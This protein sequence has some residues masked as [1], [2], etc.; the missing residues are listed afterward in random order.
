VKL[1]RFLTKSPRELSWRGLLWR[2]LPLLNVALYT[3]SIAY[4]ELVNL[5]AARTDL[6]GT[7][8]FPSVILVVIITGRWP[9]AS[10]RERLNYA[11]LSFAAPIVAGVCVYLNTRH[12]VEHDVLRDIY[13]VSSLANTGILLLHSMRWG[14]GGPWFL[15]GPVFLYGLLLENG[16]IA[17]GYFSELNYRWYLGA[18][19]APLATMS[20]WVTVFYLVLWVMWETRRQ[21]G[22]TQWRTPIL[23]FAGTSAALLLDLQIDP[24]ATAVG[25][26]TW[27][28]FLT[29]G[30][31]G[32]PLLNFVAWS[33]A[34]IPFA[35]AVAQREAKCDLWMGEIFQK[36]HRHALLWQTPWILGQ[37]TV[38]FL[39]AMAVI[40]GGFSG[41]T[42][43]I[44]TH[45]LSHLTQLY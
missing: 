30:P 39:G 35:W 22:Q 3:A 4:A 23:V 42:F 24:L 37:A 1:R 44:L 10:L 25:F 9:E 12:V 13:E 6:L 18:L 43:N 20:G 38:L 27:S 41:P 21:L 45:F 17:L 28:P 5:E 32:V 31:W 8:I 34:I 36:K 14:R 2:D 7:A 33:A 40:E 11:L 29:P 26:W 15:L 16:G 19:P